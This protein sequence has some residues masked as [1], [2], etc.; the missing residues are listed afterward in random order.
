VEAMPANLQ[1][2]SKAAAIIFLSERDVV[3]RESLLHAL[4]P[5]KIHQDGAMTK[6]P[7]REKS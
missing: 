4:T 1:V 7:N 3:A 2:A 6:V 5:A